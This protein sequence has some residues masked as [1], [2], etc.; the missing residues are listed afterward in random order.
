MEASTTQAGPLPAAG[1]SDGPPIE[2]PPADPTERLAT[3]IL[4]AL[5]GAG[6][7]AFL[8]LD[9]GCPRA[10]E[11][12]L[13]P[14]AAALMHQ[15]RGEVLVVDCR[16]QAAIP[17]RRLVDGRQPARW[18]SLCST[19]S[20]GPE[21]ERQSGDWASVLAAS[22]EQFG[23]VLLRGP[24]ADHPGAPALAA[25]CDGACLVVRLGRSGQ[26]ALSRAAEA[27]RA[28]GA[29]LLGCIAVEG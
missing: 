7:A 15:G 24:A 29:R 18:V 19:P 11:A 27:V 12:I 26:T 13:A 20:E 28:A 17:A 2:S 1:S 14:L 4:D 10:G 23:V 22:R 9:A 16:R 3:A 6:P 8:M 25:L 21:G 5:A